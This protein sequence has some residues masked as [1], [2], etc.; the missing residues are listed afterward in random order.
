MLVLAR[1]LDEKV[2]VGEVVV[3]VVEIRNGVVRLG[4]EGPIEVPIVR[5]DAVGGEN[6]A[7]QRK[8]RRAGGGRS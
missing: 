7:V 6:R 1:R 2:S 5:E 3:T 4:F 8:W